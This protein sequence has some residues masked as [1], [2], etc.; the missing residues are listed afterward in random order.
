MCARVCQASDDGICG[1]GKD[2][3]DRGDDRPGTEG[4]RR[5]LVV[6]Y[7]AAGG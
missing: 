6:V 5:C 4:P 1:D 7:V 2:A 3:D